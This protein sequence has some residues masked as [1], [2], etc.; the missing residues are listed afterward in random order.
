MA[1][2]KSSQLLSSVTYSLTAAAVVLQI[3]I[4]QVPNTHR[5]YLSIF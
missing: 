3:H 5:I 4:V 2:P 1:G